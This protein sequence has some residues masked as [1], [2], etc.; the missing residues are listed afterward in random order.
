MSQLKKKIG[1]KVLPTQDPPYC[2]NEG[3]ILTEPLQILDRRMVKK[4]NKVVVE[5][6]VQWP[7]LAPK[8]ATWEEYS[9][10]KSHFSNF[11]S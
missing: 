3:Q 2:T 6:L 5:V 8:E 10:L 9:F 7:N 1:E 11:D 4:K